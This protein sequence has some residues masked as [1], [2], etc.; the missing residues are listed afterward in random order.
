MSE[1]VIQEL[2]PS[3]KLV[4]MVI[5]YHG[6][7][8]QKQLVDETKLS[9]RTVRHALGHLEDAGIVESEIHIPDARQKMYS[10]QGNLEP[11][12]RTGTD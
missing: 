12:R 7:Q 5:Q 11:D 4:Y 6:P 9:G 2:P 3:A 10:L 8:T 1:T